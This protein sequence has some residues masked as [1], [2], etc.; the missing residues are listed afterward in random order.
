VTLQNATSGASILNPAWVQL[1]AN[2]EFQLQLGS[3]TSSGETFV[4]YVSVGTVVQQK[5]ITQAAQQ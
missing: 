4:L 1:D 5:T 2:G 3:T